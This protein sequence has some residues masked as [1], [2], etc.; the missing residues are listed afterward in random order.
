MTESNQL[1]KHVYKHIDEE[2]ISNC[3]NIMDKLFFNNS[4]GYNPKLVDFIE[5]DIGYVVSPDFKII[6]CRIVEKIPKNENEE[7]RFKVLPAEEYKIGLITRFKRFLNLNYGFKFKYPFP[8][9][10]IPE[11]TIAGTNI[12]NTYIEA[13]HF[14]QLA[15]LNDYLNHILTYNELVQRVKNNESIADFKDLIS[16]F[17]NYDKKEE[18]KNES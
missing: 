4:K 13:L 15:D 10:S 1:Y 5:G 11:K 14:I 7:F 3:K 6:R 18:N 9:N 16:T 12:F 8:W 2:L 17:K